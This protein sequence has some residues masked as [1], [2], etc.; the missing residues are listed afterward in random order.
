MV[1]ASAAN[2]GGPAAFETF[3]RDAAPRLLAL[4]YLMG[5]GD[6]APD[7]VQESMII[8]STVWDER[9]K[10]RAEGE[11]YVYVKTTLVRQIL[12]HAKVG[13]RLE[14][15]HQALAESE[16]IRSSGQ[17]H[18]AESYALE[19]LSP[20]AA[21]T[22]L[23]QLPSRQRIV[24]TLLSEGCTTAEVAEIMAITESSVRSHLQFARAKLV[25]LLS[26]EGGNDASI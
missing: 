2:P 25:D 23:D 15:L 22:A 10:Y 13:D 17:E 7:L 9:L 19:S 8:A 26:V 16:A 1:R 21:M 3:Y 5:C 4:A 6:V 20:S 11:R 18:S 24:M 14:R 12:Q